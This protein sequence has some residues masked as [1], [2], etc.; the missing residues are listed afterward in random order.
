MKKN[1]LVIGYWADS[2]LAFIDFSKT[3][4]K[5]NDIKF[6]LHKLAHHPDWFGSNRSYIKNFFH[7]FKKIS[8]IIASGFSSNVCI[9]GTNLCR[10]TFIFSF[11][12]KKTFFVYNELPENNPNSILYLID[13]LI[14]KYSKNILVSTKERADFVNSQFK[15]N[16]KIGVLENITFTEIP[17]I[18]NKSRDN[19]IVFSG[20]ITPKRFN[21]TDISKFHRINSFIERKIDVYGFVAKEISSDFNSAINKK[22]TVS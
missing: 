7:L 12:F 22:G 20:T 21:L 18:N 2:E 13:K 8:A 9:F 5:N 11:L 17:N 14:F 1:K 4:S 6:E 15:L 3:L 10:I 19:S 16:R